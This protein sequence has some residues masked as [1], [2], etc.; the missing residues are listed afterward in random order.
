MR[1]VSTRTPTTLLTPGVSTDAGQLRLVDRARQCVRRPLLRHRE[2][3]LAHGDDRGRRLLETIAR[4]VERD[5]R[6]HGD[7]HGERQA[8]RAGL[9]RPEIAQDEAEEGHG[10]TRPVRGCS[11]RSV[12]TDATPCRRS[13]PRCGCE[14]RPGATPRQPAAL[15]S[16][17]PSRWSPT[18]LSP[19]ITRTDPGST[20]TQLRGRQRSGTGHL[21]TRRLPE[22]H[23]DRR[24]G[25]ARPT[26]R[27]PGVRRI[28]PPQIAGE[29]DSPASSARAGRADALTATAGSDPHVVVQR[30]SPASVAPPAAGH[31]GPD[32]RIRRHAPTPRCSCP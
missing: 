26:E 23:A 11:S 1:S 5:D 29:I 20:A 30:G 8:D 6:H 19:P 10:S 3:G 27:S 2:I 13:P 7:R 25:Q 31:G 21:V 24:S 12:I 18:P 15:C 22:R 16:T 4:H 32:F 9:L 14:R 17:C 28:F